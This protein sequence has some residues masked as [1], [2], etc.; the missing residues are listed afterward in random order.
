M[1]SGFVIFLTVVR[2]DEASARIGF[3]LTFYLMFFFAC[4]LPLITGATSQGFDASA[5]RQFPIGRIRL[6]GITLASYAGGTEQLVCFPALL[7][8]CVVGVFAAGTPWI[9]GLVSMGLLLLFYVAWGHA[10]QLVLTGVLRR[11]RAR[12]ILAIVGFALLIGISVTPSLMLDPESHEDRPGGV[13]P[14]WG[15][16]LATAAGQSL[17][18]SLAAES[19]TRSFA[20]GREFA[21][22]LPL[23][24]LLVWDLLGL[25]LAYRAFT[26]YNLGGAESR[27]RRIAR[28]TAAAPPVAAPE[29]RPTVWT[30]DNPMLSFI[31]MQVR[32]VASKELRYLLRSVVGKFNLFM[33]PVF[34]IIVV[35][36]IARN[37]DS[38][39]L[40][41]SPDG[42]ILF[43]LLLY[44]T[45]FSNNFV[46]NAFAW[47]GEGMRTWFLVPLTPVR[48]LAGKNLAVWSYNAA[49][50]VIILVTWSVLRGVPGPRI[51]ITAVPL[52]AVSVLCFTIVGN[53]VSVL[54]PARR[55]ISSMTNSPSQ[56]A[57]LCS[58]ASLIG[59]AA[60][61]STTL[62]LAWLTGVAFLQPLFLLA[63]L[64]LLVWIHTLVLRLAGRL[65]E[66]RRDS[67]IQ[68]LATLE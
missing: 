16:R 18:P 60:L 56:L 66:R 22:P 33:M 53:V 21:A 63:V 42:V 41:I 34:V 37:V 13:L 38:S 50:F 8:V 44:A 15:H 1:G 35:F 30:A 6:F 3:N 58:L 28:T 48:V 9:T 4:I 17:P 39:F 25:F 65:M 11:R 23:A 40:G 14:P 62:L 64:A 12:E 68:T 29:R 57:V 59:S 24:L 51:L 20:T 10:I 27:S 32:A 36:L 31:P 52:Y 55:N 43:G 49:L 7:V 5:L 46:N 47:D 26:R 67:L 2:G 54:F 19:L 45:L 61:V